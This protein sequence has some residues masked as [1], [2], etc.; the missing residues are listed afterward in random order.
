MFVPSMDR[1][2]CLAPLDG[3]LDLGE[4]PI[5]GDFAPPGSDPRA[6]LR[7]DLGHALALE[8]REQEHGPMADDRILAPAR[9]PEEVGR[10]LVGQLTDEELGP[11]GHRHLLRFGSLE[12]GRLGSAITY[13]RL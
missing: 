11:A 1:R 13:R 8:A 4:H 3:I 5:A 10:L 9:L 6:P 12:Q 2:S 7:G